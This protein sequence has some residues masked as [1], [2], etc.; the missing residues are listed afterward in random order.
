MQPGTYKY[1]VSY[2][3][4]HSIPSTFH[5]KHGSVLYTAKLSIDKRFQDNSDLCKEFCVESPSD[6]HL[7]SDF[8]APITVD[9]SIDFCCCGCRPSSLKTT[10][11]IPR[12]TYVT[13]EAIPLT[14]ECHNHKNIHKFKLDIKLCKITTFHSTIPETEVKQEIQVLSELLLTN[15]DHFDTKTWAGKLKMPF[16]EIPN[17]Q[18]CAI[19][20]IQFV[21]RTT[22]SIDFALKNVRL[23]EITLLIEPGQPIINHEATEKLAPLAKEMEEFDSLL[24]YDKDTRK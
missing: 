13:G 2:T 1:E 18:K 22:A 6:N 15:K 9:N 5:G 17:L 14:V 19:I 3:L 7:Y 20:D 4:P 11:T 8:D 12:G 21:I 23:N 10:T 24:A 16:I